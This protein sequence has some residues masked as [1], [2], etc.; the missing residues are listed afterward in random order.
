[1]LTTPIYMC[2][3]QWYMHENTHVHNAGSQL[4]WGQAS[5]AP[6]IM[7]TP[8]LG[9]WR[10]DRQHVKHTPTL[11][12]RFGEV[13]LGGQPKLTYRLPVTVCVSGFTHVRDGASSSCGEQGLR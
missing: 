11:T 7:D 2:T 13:C 8:W 12:H 5:Q 9:E 6:G 1:M 3:G 4:D 10:T